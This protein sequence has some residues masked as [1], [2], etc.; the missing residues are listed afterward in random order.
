MRYR[1][2]INDV[3]KNVLLQK[4]KD[5]KRGRVDIN[6]IERKLQCVSGI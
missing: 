6:E 4:K 2:P 5:C 3:T 1:D